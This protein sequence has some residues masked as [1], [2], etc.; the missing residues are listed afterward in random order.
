MSIVVSQQQKESYY[1][2]LFMSVVDLLKAYTNFIKE[3]NSKY[4][5]HELYRKLNFCL[6][7]IFHF[8]AGLTRK[9]VFVNYL[10]ER[11]IWNDLN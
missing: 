3:F 6:E 4:L 8:I 2:E 9:N 1:T 11:Q 7:I 10:I 5:N